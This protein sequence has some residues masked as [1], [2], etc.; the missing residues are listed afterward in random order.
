MSRI[1]LSS[2]RDVRAGDVSEISPLIRIDTVSAISCSSEQKDV[3]I[4]RLLNEAKTEIRV[5][6]GR[7]WNEETVV[8]LNFF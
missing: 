8:V 7:W 6:V 4:W 5:G 3:S 1:S 2:A